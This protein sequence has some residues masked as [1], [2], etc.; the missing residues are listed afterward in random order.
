MIGRLAMR[1]IV[2]GGRGF[3][4]RTIIELMR[5]AGLAL[6]AGSRG[7]GGDIVFNVEDC[8]SLRAAL[9]PDD[10]VIDTVGPFQDRSTALVEAAIEIRFDVIDLSDSIAYARKIWELK[11]RIDSAGIRVLTACSAMS[12]ISAALVHR[13]GI[14]EPVRVTGFIAPASRH[15]ANSATG[16]SLLRS[17][18]QP[19][20]VLRDGNLVTRIGWLDRRTIDFSP[21][22]GRIQGH[23][24]EA[25]DSFLLPKV[26]PSLRTSDYFVDSRVPCLNT[27]FTV[28]AHS[29][30][31]R[32]LMERSQPLGLVFA[33]RFGATVGGLGYEIEDADGTVVRFGL[34]T[35]DRAFRIA[36]VPSVLA[37][38][39]IAAGRFEH[40]GLISCDALVIADE[41]FGYL[42]DLG[43]RVEQL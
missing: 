1:I 31:L 6:L 17:I 28:A 42:S 26:W 14:T 12:A 9:Q 23:L 22:L 24:F 18:G 10:I 36:A 33:R 43:V 20:E 37:A 27:A 34:T 8:E 32:R 7:P 30:L 13:T 5:D 4:G 21:P 38:R 29:P 40:R 11:P 35:E 25:V 15:S 41:L 39:N 19:I 3:F 2:A 16:A